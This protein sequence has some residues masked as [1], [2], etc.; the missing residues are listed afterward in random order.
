MD[1]TGKIMSYLE[2][3]SGISLI[4]R[5]H[6]LVSDL[7]LSSKEIIDFAIFFYGISEK[8][9]SFGRDLSVGEILQ[10]CECRENMGNFNAYDYFFVERNLKRNNG[11]SYVIISDAEKITYEQFCHMV[12]IDY[13][14]FFREI[15]DCSRMGILLPDSGIQQV[16]YW[17]GIKHGLT[18]A[19]FPVNESADSVISIMKRAKIDLIITDEEHRDILELIRAEG[20]IRRAYTVDSG[21]IIPR[22]YS[23]TSSIRK[24]EGKMILF[25]S[26]TTGIY[27]GVIHGQKDI[28]VAAETYGEQILKLTPNDIMYS[29]SHLNYGFAFTN[30]TFQTFYG[31]AASII[32]K[33][34][35]IWTIAANINKYKPTV[36]CG[37]PAL[38]EAIGEIASLGKTD[39]SSVRLALSSG[40]KISDRL[41]NFWKEN[42]GITI[43]DGYGSVEM[44]TNVL[45]NSLDNYVKGSSGK[46]LEGF[47]ADFEV[48]SDDIKLLKVKGD[49]ISNITIDSDDNTSDTYCTNDI[50]MVDNDGFFWYKGRADDVY[51]VN[52][53]WFNPVL[54]ENYLENLPNIKGASIVNLDMRLTAF[55]ITDECDNFGKEQAIS[56]NKYLKHSEG[57]NICPDMY[58]LVNELPRN[59]NGKKIRIKPNN[60]SIIRSIEV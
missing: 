7:H 52:G 26:G 15:S 10:M 21:N 33:D 4:K 49:S 22:W 9:I 25:S 46:M 24:K 38:F 56:I 29:M 5:E 34:T 28:K 50:F 20:T 17:G 31:G 37:V 27:K 16:F 3:T 40:E 14:T 13:A 39:V 35:D 12:E 47:E 41:W 36:L 2:K 54:I 45:S 42:F 59:K 48:L 6:R 19:I 18:S 43:I 57:Q 44:V 23:E 32:D 51:K 8:K 53:M 60:E 11:S 30:S 58:V 1:I 55:I